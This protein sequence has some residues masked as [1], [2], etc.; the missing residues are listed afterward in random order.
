MDATPKKSS[1][2]YNLKVKMLNKL[3]QKSY[4][5]DQFELIIKKNKNKSLTNIGKAPKWL[6]CFFTVRL[7]YVEYHT[8]IYTL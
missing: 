5:T 2:K 7:I 6:S 8:Y 4:P 1:K 3:C